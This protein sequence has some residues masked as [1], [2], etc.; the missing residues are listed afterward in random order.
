[1]PGTFPQGK[2][3]P[4]CVTAADLVVTFFAMAGMN[5]PWTMHGR[6]LT[7][8]LKAPEGPWEHPAFYEYTGEHFGSDV[9]R[10]VTNAPK[11]ATYHEIPWYVAL[12]DER[13]KYIRYLTPG[14]TEELYDLTADP[15]ELHNLADR[16]ENGATLRALRGRTLAELN[17]TGADFA[18]R[19]PATKQMRTGGQ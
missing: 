1:M 5:L 18:D 10:I 9:T 2:V 17:R 4:R 14:E 12:R 11:E 3:S 15:D 7:P 16:V 13:W 6:D 8:L 19:L